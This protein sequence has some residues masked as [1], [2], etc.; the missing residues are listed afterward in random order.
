LALASASKSDVVSELDLA[1]VPV[2]AHA[3]VSVKAVVLVLA[4]LVASVAKAVVS[5]VLW[6]AFSHKAANSALK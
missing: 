3:L 4:V 6:G 5:V 1:L 2:S